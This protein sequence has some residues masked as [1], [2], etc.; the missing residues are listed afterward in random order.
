[1]GA[2]E[3]GE[4]FVGER[5]LFVFLI[6]GGFDPLF[7]G[8]MRDGACARVR[9]EEPEWVDASRRGKGFLFDSA[10]DGRFVERELMSHVLKRERLQIRCFSQKKI[11]L[12]F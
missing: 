4:R 9:K 1:L 2:E 8:V 7:D 6:N 3:G 11:M 12:Y 10:G 5:R